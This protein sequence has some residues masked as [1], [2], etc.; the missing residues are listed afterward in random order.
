MS[1]ALLDLLVFLLLVL[2]LGLLVGLRS[3]SRLGHGSGHM[4][5]STAFEPTNN[6]TALVGWC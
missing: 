5:V 3:V 2:A 6:G 4:F 1:L